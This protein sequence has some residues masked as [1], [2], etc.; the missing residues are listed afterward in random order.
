V[1][2]LVVFACESAELK[3]GDGCLG[4]AIPLRMKMPELV[5]SRKKDEPICKS[6]NRSAWK[7][8][9]RFYLKLENQGAPSQ[10]ILAVIEITI[11]RT[12][13][14]SKDSVRNQGANVETTES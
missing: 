5:D 10:R 8:R 13:E 2:R 14:E 1:V 6:Y 12:R 11:Y 9:N 3:P 4:R 7:V